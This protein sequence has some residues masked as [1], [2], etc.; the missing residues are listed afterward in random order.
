MNAIHFLLSVLLGAAYASAW[1]G[2]AVFGCSARTF[3]LWLLPGAATLGLGLMSA[4][5]ISDH[6]KDSQ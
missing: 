6:W 4:S 2:A 1:W 5:W 3:G